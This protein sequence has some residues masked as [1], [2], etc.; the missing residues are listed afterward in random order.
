M[1]PAG[2]RSCGDEIPDAAR[3]CP[4]CGTA[5]ALTGFRP[6]LKL[7]EAR[8][9]ATDLLCVL[10]I[11]L[12]LVG[13]AF[14]ILVVKFGLAHDL[15]WGDTPFWLGIP[16]FGAAVIGA[17]LGIV[18]IT[19]DVLQLLRVHLVNAGLIELVARGVD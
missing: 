3:F 12:C 4:Q 2:C 5:L 11:A 6:A 15:E 17:M 10:G 13:C 16:G 19:D 9:H 1:R 18:Q 14:P 8:F 7:L